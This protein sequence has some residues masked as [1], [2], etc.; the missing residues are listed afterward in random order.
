MA[1]VVPMAFFVLRGGGEIRRLSLQSDSY[2]LP[3]ERTRPSV[4]DLGNPQRQSKQK[5]ERR[6]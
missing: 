6:V 2:K 4:K 1:L 3:G 5:I